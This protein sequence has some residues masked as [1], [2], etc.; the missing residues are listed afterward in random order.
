LVFKLKRKTIYASITIIMLA[1]I[2]CASPTKA[3]TL[4]YNDQL[5]KAADY[6]RN[7]YDQNM[8]LVSESEDTG[9]NIPD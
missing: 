6:I 2:I 3:E 5:Q 8:G 1:N 7:R 9:S 4:S